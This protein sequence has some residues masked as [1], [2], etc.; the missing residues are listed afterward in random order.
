M[1]KTVWGHFDESLEKEIERVVKELQKRGI[2]KPTKKEASAL[3]A[4]RNNIAYM[5]DKEIKEFILKVR[6]FK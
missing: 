6:G 2:P 4:L 3:I 1:G 5:S